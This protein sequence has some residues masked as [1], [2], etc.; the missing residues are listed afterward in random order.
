[1]TP[2]LQLEGNLSEEGLLFTWKKWEED[3]LWYKLLWSQD[4]PDPIYP[5][6]SSIFYSADRE[7]TTY[8]NTTLPLGKSFYRLC[9]ITPSWERHCSNV[10]VFD[11]Y[12]ENE[13]NCR[14]KPLFNQEYCGDLGVCSV[15]DSQ[16]CPVF[17][18]CNSAPDSEKETTC[19]EGDFF[20]LNPKDEICTKYENTCDI[21]KKSI[22]QSSCS[23]EVIPSFCDTEK[24]SYAYEGEI[25][26]LSEEESPCD[27]CSEK[28]DCSLSEED[29]SEILC[30]SQDISSQDDNEEK[31]SD[32][33]LPEVSPEEEIA[34]EIK[35]EL[36]E[37]KT[38]KKNIFFTDVSEET[39]QGKAIMEY[40]SRGVINGFSDGSFG[41]EKTVTRAEIAKITTLASGHSVETPKSSLFCD[42][43]PDSWFAPFV[44][45]F[46]ENG[47][48]QGFVGGDC[49]L[50]RYFSPHNPVLR[51]EAIKMIFEILQI[52]VSLLEKQ[53]LTGFPDVTADHW[54]APYARKA[55]EGNIFRGYDD[56]NFYPDV[57]ATRGEIVLFLKRAEAL[58]KGE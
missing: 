12:P 24:I 21:P 38:E 51:G 44:H 7:S 14:K 37:K 13:N 18:C 28:E 1:M 15:N 57:P 26:C 58:Q 22:L 32:R 20:A 2:S 33:E 39:E 41:G 9:V 35:E 4:N 10:F 43:S 3:F 30:I 16:G 55:W 47:Y 56:G 11:Y 17:F 6:D 45:Y 46:S 31:P 25:L 54:L 40:A 5:D 29:P 48:A 49:P 42:V 53:E 36:E 8:L 50:Q 34:K 23:E 27:L 52:E 19:K